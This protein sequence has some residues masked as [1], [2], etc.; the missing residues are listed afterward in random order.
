MAPTAI[1]NRWKNRFII[2]A[3][4]AARHW[5]SR[6]L[7]IPGALGNISQALAPNVEG[8]GYEAERYREVQMIPCPIGHIVLLYDNSSLFRF[9]WARL[10]S[11]MRRSRFLSHPQFLSARKE[12][13]S[14]FYT[15]RKLKKA[16]CSR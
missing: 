10:L 1:E 5:L 11:A 6:N 4:A 15:I 2:P 8:D 3:K 13:R 7:R 9:V 14:C 16:I 12:E